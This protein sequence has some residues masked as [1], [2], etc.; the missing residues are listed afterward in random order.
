MWGDEQ[1]F[2]D[3]HNQ[4]FCSCAA[5]VLQ[6]VPKDHIPGKW[7]IIDL[8]AKSEQVIKLKLVIVQDRYLN[9][10]F[11]I[12]NTSS[13]EHLQLSKLYRHTSLLVSGMSCRHEC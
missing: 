3:F 7:K 9:I 6:L 1:Q 4:R 13:Q 10:M 2:H 11:V 8:S 12:I 5:M